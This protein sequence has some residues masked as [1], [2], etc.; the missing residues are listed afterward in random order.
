MFLGK[1]VLKIFS[2][3][4]GEHPYRSVISTKLQSNFIEITLR[5]GCSPVNVMHIFKTPFPN[6]TFG[7]L[8]LAIIDKV[9]ER[10]ISSIIAKNC[11][12]D[13]KGQSETLVQGH[14]NTE[15]SWGGGGKV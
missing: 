7:R 6:N 4:T 8:L 9:C 11:S 3:F 10:C 1:A 2:K 15:N 14:S 12:R 5:H 13:E